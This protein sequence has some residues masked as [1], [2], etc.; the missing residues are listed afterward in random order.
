MRA[1]PDVPGALLIT[2]AMM[3]GRLH[4]RRPGGAAGLAGPADARPG[5]GSL[6][7]L[8]AFIVRQRTARHPLVP[9]RIFAARNVTG[10]NLVQI[11][12]TAGMFGMFF[13]GSL[14]LRRDPGVRPAADRAGL[15]A[16]GRG[17]GTLSVRYTDRLVMRFGA[18]ALMFGGLALIAAGLALF[19][20]APAHGGGYLA[21]VFPVTVAIGAGRA[22]ASRR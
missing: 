22:C 4:H 18:R 16:G 5:G 2:A 21:Y 11:L 1:A 17:M 14:Y 6:V 3:L 15:P 7:L 8:A 9:L 20:L 12:G 10:A 13:L 19:A